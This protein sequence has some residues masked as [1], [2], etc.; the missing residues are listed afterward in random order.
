MLVI[1]RNSKKTKKLVLP[2]LN[3]IIFHTLIWAVTQF[4][5]YYNYII[6][7]DSGTKLLD[8]VT[9]RAAVEAALIGPSGLQ[10]L[11]CYF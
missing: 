4:R 3:Q 8:L 5:L 6:N 1:V 7:I 2:I 11:E 10:E 9:L